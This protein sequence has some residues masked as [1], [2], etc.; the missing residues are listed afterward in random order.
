[1]VRTDFRDFVDKIRAT[2][3]VTVNNTVKGEKVEISSVDFSY[4]IDKLI[5]VQND[6]HILRMRLNL[7]DSVVKWCLNYI[8][9]VYSFSAI[10][11]QNNL[12]ISAVIFNSDLLNIPFKLISNVTDNIKKYKTFLYNT[13]KTYRLLDVNI[14]KDFQ[15]LA[16][17]PVPDFGELDAYTQKIRQDYNQ[18]VFDFNKT[19]TASSFAFMSF[20]Q[21]VPES[22]WDA[23]NGKLEAVMAEFKL[24]FSPQFLIKQNFIGELLMY[25]ATSIFKYVPQLKID[26]PD[27]FNL[28][29]TIEGYVKRLAAFWDN[30][31]NLCLE[32]YHKQPHEVHYQAANMFSPAEA[33]NMYT[34]YFENRNEDYFD[35]D[36]LLLLQQYKHRT[37]KLTFVDPTNQQ[38]SDIWRQLFTDSVKTLTHDERTHLFE[39]YLNYMDTTTNVFDK[40]IMNKMHRVYMATEGDCL[41]DLKYTYYEQLCF[42]KLVIKFILMRANM[43]SCPQFSGHDPLSMLVQEFV[44]R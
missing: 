20:F 17:P 31:V 28:Q 16:S 4:L 3:T 9:F 24:P 26:F 29:Y 13:Y 7:M 33:S 44:M 8:T 34:K 15:A 11:F 36:T 32:P 43:L 35:V 10:L 5:I 19:D 23:L 25:F 42:A 38:I 18:F 2:N 27:K 40:K 12:P 30:Q 6:N 37:P 21:K 14:A 41:T 1:M 22:D 39:S